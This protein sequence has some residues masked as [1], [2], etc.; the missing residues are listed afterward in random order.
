MAPGK[1]ISVK[2]Q[3]IRELAD[4]LVKMADEQLTPVENKMKAIDI[5][6]PQFGIIGAAFSGIH[7][8]AKNQSLSNVGD[9]KDTMDAWRQGLNLTAWG[10]DKAEESSTANN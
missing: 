7:I 8:V 2:G 4:Q 1:N 6:F 5:G 9:A 3:K 10:W